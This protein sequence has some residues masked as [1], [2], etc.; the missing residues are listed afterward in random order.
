MIKITSP[1]HLKNIDDPQILPYIRQLLESLLKEYRQFCPDSSIEKIGIIFL[2]EQESDFDLY[3]EMGLLSPVSTSD[4]E[5]I[6]PIENGYCNGCIVIDND[7]AIN[8]I[9]KEEYFNKYK[10][11]IS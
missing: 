3:Q 5:W 6:A 7:R 2:L 9:G 8:V 1:E 4:F 10:E 11:V